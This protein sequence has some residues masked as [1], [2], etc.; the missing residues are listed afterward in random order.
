MA[1]SDQLLQRNKDLEATCAHKEA[2]IIAR[3]QVYVITFLDPGTEPSASLELASAPVPG[4]PQFEVAVVHTVRADAER[5]RSG[6]V[7]PN[8]I[9]ISGHVY[10]VTTGPG[11]TG[12]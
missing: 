7:L 5:L 8:T 3:H 9:S 1:G 12:E 10:E 6:T 11:Q 4:E 2:S